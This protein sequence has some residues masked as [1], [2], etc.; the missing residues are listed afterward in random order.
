MDYNMEK[1]VA[2]I[3]PHGKKAP[4]RKKIVAKKDS[5]WRKSSK[6]VPHLEKNRFST[7]GGCERLLL[8]PPRQAP[9][10]LA[11]NNIT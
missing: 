6:K 4:H 10:L 7:G 9:M 3:P 1:I 8:P 11:Y 2:K 5:T